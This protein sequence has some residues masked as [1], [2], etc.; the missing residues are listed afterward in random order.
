MNIIS[1]TEE[2]EI[3]LGEHVRQ[4]RLQKNMDRETLSSQAGISLTAIKNLEGGKGATVKT[5]LK[6][7]RALGRIDWIQSLAP[8]ASINPLLMVNT[9]SARQRASRHRVS[10]QPAS[11]ANAGKP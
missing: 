4:L 6:V 10:T 9:K 8:V 5:L 7:L 2:Y 11:H 1:N 3:T